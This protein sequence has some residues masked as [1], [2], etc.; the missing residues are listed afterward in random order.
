[1]SLAQ[2]LA[3]ITL[4]ALRGRFKMIA[5]RT[6]KV[7]I[8][9]LLCASCGCAFFRGNEI[10]QL[11]FLVKTGTLGSMPACDEL[12]ALFA[13]QPALHVNPYKPPVLPAGEYC[14]V[15]LIDTSGN[16]DEASFIWDW[17]GIH[18]VVRHHGGLGST[19]P[20]ELTS[21]L[22]DELV[23]IIKARYADAEVTRFTAYANPLFGP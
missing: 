8:G 15:T 22:S 12:S 3:T 9:L 13:K 10:P 19:T 17:Q 6:V 14:D 1:M 2:W 5:T 18:L 23:D 11:G 4:L 20:N 16:H 21:R 7:L